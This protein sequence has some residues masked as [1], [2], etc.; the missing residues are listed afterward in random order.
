[1]PRLPPFLTV[2]ALMVA[3]AGLTGCASGSV[4]DIGPGND[5]LPLPSSLD[6]GVESA[7]PSSTAQAPPRNYASNPPPSNPA[8]SSDEDAATTGTESSSDASSGGVCNA[9]CSGCCDSNG[10]CDTSGYDTSC[11]SGA[12]ACEDCTV[13]GGTCQGGQC[14]SSGSAASS[15]SSGGSTQPGSMGGSLF[16]SSGSSDGGLCILGICI[17]TGPVNGTGPTTR[18]AGA[19][20]LPDAG[21]LVSPTFDAGRRPDAG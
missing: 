20:S 13:T 5:D 16:P 19:H 1:M 15:S 10:N 6:S 18:D 3:L 8:G 14:V 12:Q 11:G 7:A 21:L 17:P 2:A 4:D 9:T